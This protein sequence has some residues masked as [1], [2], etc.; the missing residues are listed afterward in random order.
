[1]RRL[2]VG[3]LAGALAL[4]AS[5]AMADDGPVDAGITVPRV[6]GMGADWINGVD[7]STVLS[8]EA[9]GVVFRDEAGQPADL[10]EVL[11]DHGVNWTRIRVW[12]DPFTA[13]GAGYGGGNVDAA[14]AIEIGQR[15][16]AAGMQVLVDFHYS[17]FWAHPGQ[18]KL[19]KAWRGLDLDGRIT[20]LHDYTA[21]TLAS[22]AA[23]GVD[24]GMVQ[25]GNETTGGEIAGTTGWDDTARLFQAGSEAVRSTLGP[26]V[27]VAVHFTNPERAGQY[28]AAA[29]ALDD[30]GVDYDVF[31][32]SYYPFW[33]GTPENLTAVLDQVATT[34]GKDVAVAET[35]WAYTLADGDGYPNVIRTEP[36]AYPATVQGQ[37]SAVRDVMQAVANVSGGH[38]LGTFYWE[39]AWL[40]VGPA[41]QAAANR[42]LWDRDGSGWASPASQEFYDPD[43]ALGGEW[44]DDFGGSGWDNQA[45]FAHDGTP[46]ESLRVYQYAV[47]GSVAPREVDAVTNP[48]LTVVDG[49]P[50][51]LPTTVRVSYNDGTSEDQA[52]TWRGDTAWI[53]GAGTYR[54][55]G[56]TTGGHPV[57]ATVTV[58][59]DA[60]QGTN[61]VVN[62]GFEDG[63]APWTGTGT[64]YTISS[65]DDPYA[66]NRSVH[67]WSGSAYSFTVEQTLTGV[68]A[69]QYRLS[70]QVQGDGSG[71]ADVTRISASSG[72]SSV[73]ADFRLSGYKNWQQPQTAPLAVASDG[74]VVVSASFQLSAG[75]WGTLDEVAL[76]AMPTSAA[77][78]VAPLRSLV[79]DADAI[80]RAAFTAASLVALDRAVDRGRFVL[81]A[82]SPGQAAVD[83]AVAELRTA[84]AG[85]E[86][87]PDPGAPGTPDPGTP[88]PGTPDPGTPN[89]GTPNPG[90]P[91]SGTAQA[92]G[93]TSGR[94]TSPA[95][96]LATTGS[97]MAG[98]VLA[99]GLLL[100]GGVVVLGAV[101]AVRRRPSGA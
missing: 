1:M 76:V 10:F 65:T 9:S 77:G 90:T 42:L 66:G 71:S 75:A 38:G 27:K 51:T 55:T 36:S 25:I 3:I 59:A 8:L 78:D 89:P 86:R 97:G 44:A 84:L 79:D 87:A 101:R 6:E 61:L 22:M 93:A 45:M 4:G 29:K 43:G 70:A 2:M 99:A 98:P 21:D 69:G 52:V 96:T 14:R 35:S 30:R 28:A 81:D 47:T 37:A 54:V 92:P 11:A 94:P 57:V 58:L 5:P 23:A 34:Y 15:A 50:I 41:D 63:V 100:L 13:D 82:P 17:D 68:P 48:A 95:S 40:P 32:S 67:F 39:P 73:S 24:V 33:H 64:G 20:A 16:T 19:P 18:Q 85:L 46:L 31:L 72:I 62:S 80:D 26:Q 91:A 53:L 49:D 83:A 12:N 74:V 7:V 60:G 56:V 88:D